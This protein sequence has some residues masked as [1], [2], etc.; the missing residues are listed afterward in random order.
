MTLN[1][2]A[3]GAHTTVPTFPNSHTGAAESLI[4][5][6][7]TLSVKILGFEVDPAPPALHTARETPQI[8]EIWQAE[9]VIDYEY[10][11]CMHAES[12]SSLTWKGNGMKRGM[13][14]IQ[15][16]VSFWQLFKDIK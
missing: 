13:I 7:V 15:L 9:Y 4:L 11:I 16:M 2:T 3:H 12:W 5:H 8:P 10:A 1:Y 14:M 6:Y